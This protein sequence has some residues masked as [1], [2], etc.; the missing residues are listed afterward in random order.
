[1]NPPRPPCFIVGMSRAGT[2][3]MSRVLNEHSRIAAFGESLF[4]GRGYTEPGADGAYSVEQMRALGRRLARNRWGPYGNAAG[5]LRSA[6][7]DGWDGALHETIA[8]SFDAVGAPLTPAACYERLCDAVRR[9]EDKPI[10]VEKTPHHLNWSDRIWRA[11]PGARFIVMLREPYGFMRSYKHQGDRL[12]PDVRRAFQR[13]YHPIAAALVWRG[14]RAAAAALTQRA[15]EQA[16]VVHLDE[17]THDEAAVLERVQRLIGVD[18]EPLAGRVSAA[19]TS[20]P[21]DHG[22]LP[23]LDAADVFWM[24]RIAGRRIRTHGYTAQ[25]TPRGL[26]VIVWSVLRLPG[27]VAWNVRDM[28]RRT[29]GPLWRYLRRWVVPAE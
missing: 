17:L 14:Y 24:N 29:S 26:W 11:F 13:R 6:G 27:W 8:S 9:C 28:R 4:W 19:N 20:F 16:V 7:S 21:S 18:V 2:T 1:M 3:W 12:S 10:V 25:Q 15:P 22:A 5:A 23:A